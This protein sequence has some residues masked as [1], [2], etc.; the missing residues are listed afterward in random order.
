[1]LL[2]QLLAPERVRVPLLGAD[3]TALITELIDVL[4]A[5]ECLADPKVALEAVLRRESERTTGI[6]YGL[7]IPHGKTDACKQVVMA[8]GK[9]QVPVDFQSYDKKPVSFVVMLISPSDQTSSH[10]QALAKL[11]SLMTKPAF[12]EAVE[13]AATADELYDVVATFESQTSK[14]GGGK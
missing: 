6:G 5:N 14:G 4:A 2:S 1:M 11:S 9:P 13:Q 12:R 3:K 8:A 10:I 7:A